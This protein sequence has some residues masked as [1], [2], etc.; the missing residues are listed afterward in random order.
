MGEQLRGK[1]IKKSFGEFKWKINKQQDMLWEN[2]TL[3]KSV[4]KVMG[5]VKVKQKINK[6]LT[7]SCCL[8]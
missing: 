2:L 7:P 4:K 5:K 6:D 3:S 8:D 1:S